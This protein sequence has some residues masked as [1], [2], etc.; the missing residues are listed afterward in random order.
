MDL[1]VPSVG[2]IFW[3]TLTF[4]IVFLLLRKMA[5]KPIL[6]ALK[7]RENSIQHALDSA[8]KAKEEM[9]ALQSSN[10]AILLEARNE[11]DKLLKE[12]RETK[13]GIIA[14]A[15]AGAQK[16]A[17]KI[18]QNARESIQSEK[19][20]AMD[21]LKNQVAK[22]SIEIA[23]KIIRTEL[24]SD[25]KQKALVNTLLDEVNSN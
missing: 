22:L 10:E 17:D 19:T 9:I 21:E 14:E 3:M 12:A 18:M 4:L 25:E 7:E 20:A 11:R 24:S 15:K 13:D 2:L 16:E 1:I 8:Q 5:W 6:G 23:E